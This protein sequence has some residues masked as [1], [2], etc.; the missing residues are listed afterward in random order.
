M[1]P[2]LRVKVMRRDRQ[3]VDCT[4]LLLLLLLLLLGAAVAAADN[5]SAAS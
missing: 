5:R 1:L 2:L 3:D 4:R